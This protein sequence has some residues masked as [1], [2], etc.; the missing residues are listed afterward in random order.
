MGLILFLGVRGRRRLRFLAA[1]RRDELARSEVAGTQSFTQS[2]R[3]ATITSSMS[4]SIT[5]PALVFGLRAR[6]LF[7]FCEGVLACLFV[8]DVQPVL[9]DDASFQVAPEE[10]L[11]DLLEIEAVHTPVQRKYTFPYLA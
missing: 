2:R 1:P 6:I 10:A 9:K 3:T 7:S 5:I 11:C 8:F 4:P